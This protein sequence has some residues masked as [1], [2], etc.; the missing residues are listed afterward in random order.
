VAHLTGRSHTRHH[1][2]GDRIYAI[3]VSDPARPVIT[4]SIVANSRS[5]NDHDHC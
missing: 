5:M 2:G 1:V 4:D 3:D